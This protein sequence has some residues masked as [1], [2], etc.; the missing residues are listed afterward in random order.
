M[1]VFCAYKRQRVLFLFKF[2]NVFQPA[3]K[4]GAELVEGVGVDVGVLPQSVQ[5]PGTEAVLLDEGI[6]GDLLFF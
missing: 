4:D 3:I 2:C 5:L 1:R 6:L